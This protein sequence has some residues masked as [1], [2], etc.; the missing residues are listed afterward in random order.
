M[1]QAERRSGN[2]WQNRWFLKTKTL[3]LLEF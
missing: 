1:N 2:E 3:K